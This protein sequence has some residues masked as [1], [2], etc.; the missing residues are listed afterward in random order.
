[1]Q[2][3]NTIDSDFARL[4]GLTPSSLAMFLDLFSHV[5]QS[6]GGQLCIHPPP[7]NLPAVQ[8]CFRLRFEAAEKRY[9]RMKGVVSASLAAQRELQVEN[10]RLMVA[11]SIRRLGLES[12]CASTL[13]AMVGGGSNAAIAVEMQTLIARLEAVGLENERLVT[14][15]RVLRGEQVI[16][17]AGDDMMDSDEA[18]Y[19]HRQ[20]ES[21]TVQTSVQRQRI[22]Q[23]ELECVRQQ[24][25]PSL[26]D[27][28]ERL[29]ECEDVFDRILG[30]T[31]LDFCAEN[32]PG[33][34]LASYHPIA[35]CQDPACVAYATRLRGGL[36][37]A[38]TSEYVK[39]RIERLQ[40]L[41]QLKITPLETL[42]VEK[43]KVIERLQQRICR[44]EQSMRMTSEEVGCVQLQALSS[45]IFKTA[46]ELEGL[47]FRCAEE[48]AE[49]LRWQTLISN[50]VAD[51]AALDE[52]L[53]C[54]RREIAALID[55][56]M[57]TQNSRRL[58]VEERD[59]T[60]CYRVDLARFQD[61]HMGALFRD[62]KAKLEALQREMGFLQMESV[63]RTEVDAVQSPD[64]SVDERPVMSKKAKR[65]APC[66]EVFP[67][68]MV[69]NV[70]CKCGQSVPLPQME[71]H[72]RQAH[73][74]GTRKPL[75]CTSGCGFFLVNGSKIDMEKHL[76]SDQ[77]KKRLVIIRK[78]SA[79]GG[80]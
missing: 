60:S 15:N 32:I 65:Q 1:M 73:A 76:R 49:Y 25:N 77:C 58:L 14:F 43:D 30:R 5:N 24:S 78:M 37:K 69:V 64:M 8:E 68:S 12:A 19:L 38:V 48:R 42:R 31:R 41:I 44:F 53:A 70:L 50:L 13:E 34:A 40:G 47:R 63:V 45:D 6:E 16:A 52:E 4:H 67:G 55:E 2:F 71:A 29:R 62:Q 11:D 28:D 57:L 9:S 59:L 51:H 20:I 10:Q 26:F 54:T 74:C 23:L 80:V 17:Y 56:R 3:T 21:L 36:R 33:A 7:M 39:E 66:F 18:S 72:A 75:I 79:A 61:G 35:T 46:T 27:H 22:T